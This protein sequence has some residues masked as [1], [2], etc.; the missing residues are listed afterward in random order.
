MS[1]YK[2]RGKMKPT[3]ILVFLVCMVAVLVVA[4]CSPQFQQGQ[5][6]GEMAQSAISTPTLPNPTL[7]PN[8]VVVTATPEPTTPNVAEPTRQVTC[9]NGR[10]VPVLNGGQ[11]FYATVNGV[12]GHNDYLVVY[13]PLQ[14]GY[15][16]L[17]P[18]GWWY[19]PC[20]PFPGREAHEV[21][22]TLHPGH[23]RFVGPECMV[24]HNYDG[25]HPFDTGTLLVDRANILSL[26]VEET[27]GKGESWIFVRCNRGDASGFSFAKLPE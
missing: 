1:K 11:V 24:F 2:E 7:T 12:N 10:V 5:T 3:R 14:S 13:D 6:I 26:R 21:A 17:Q 19:Q 25:K 16:D 15:S 9:S 20:L 18:N 23:Y 8:V 27:L 4:A 22:L